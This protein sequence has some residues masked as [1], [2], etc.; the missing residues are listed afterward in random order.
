[1]PVCSGHSLVAAMATLSSEA[2]S[3][4]GS[5]CPLSRCRLQTRLHLHLHLPLHLPR[6]SP[7]RD[8]APREWSEHLGKQEPSRDH[9][10]FPDRKAAQGQTEC[11]PPPCPPH[12]CALLNR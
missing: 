7:R 5:P 12:P 8:A 4:H 10:H 1:M 6:Q 9:G 11:S 3:V 2:T